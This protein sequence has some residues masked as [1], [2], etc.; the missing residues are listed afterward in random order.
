ME[1][2]PIDELANLPMPKAKKP[3]NRAQLNELTLL[4][5]NKGLKKLYSESNKFVIS[6]DSKNDLKKLMNLYKE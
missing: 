6:G 2:T 1:D 5:E 4:H 3:M